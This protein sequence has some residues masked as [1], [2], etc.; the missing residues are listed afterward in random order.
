MLQVRR[1]T[2]RKGPSLSPCPAAL[3][4]QLV[5]DRTLL[6]GLPP[7]S[8]PVWPPWARS[9]SCSPPAAQR[10]PLEA[11]SQYSSANGRMLGRLSAGECCHGN[12]QVGLAASFLELTPGQQRLEIHAAVAPAIGWLGE[13]AGRGLGLERSTGHL[14]TFRRHFNSR[15]AYC[16]PT[17]CPHR[18]ESF[19]S[20][21]PSDPPSGPGCSVFHPTDENTD[22]KRVSDFTKVTHTLR[23]P[24]LLRPV[25]VPFSET[26]KKLYPHLINALTEPNM[27]NRMPSAGLPL[28]SRPEWGGG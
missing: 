15:R 5:R 20:P 8:V 6:E 7:S 16:T 24:R 27:E 22:S 28:S 9:P 4:A 10:R 23:G 18:A 25:C 19:H 12:W 14:A 17:V 11:W 3:L 21:Y 2:G 26:S 13:T 1:W